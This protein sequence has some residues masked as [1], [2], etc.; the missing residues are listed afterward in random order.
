MWFKVELTESGLNVLVIESRSKVALA[1]HA[2]S[3]N[4]VTVYI[5]A[6]KPNM[7]SVSCTVLSQE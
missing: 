3:S 7:E 5:P 6:C 4:T 1:V 2:L